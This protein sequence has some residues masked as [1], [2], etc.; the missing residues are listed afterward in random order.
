[1]Q[2]TTPTGSRTTSEF[3]TCSSKTVS[4]TAAGI[5]PKSIAGSPAWIMVESWRGIP[6]SREMSAAI[7][8]ERSASFADIAWQAAAR[9]CAGTCDHCSKAGRAART[10]RSTSSASLA[11]MLPMTCSVVESTTSNVPL[12]CG[13]TH[14]P[15]M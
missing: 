11:G 1:M 6:T 13:S 10:A 15:P 14:S 12:P 5:D 4:S 2:P 3:P 8:A 7:S 9:S